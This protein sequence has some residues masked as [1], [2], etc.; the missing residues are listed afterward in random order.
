MAVRRFAA[1]AAPGVVALTLA[2]GG[3]S[4]AATRATPRIVAKPNNLMVDTKTTLT[5]SGFPARTRLSIVECSTTNWVVTAHPCVSGNKVSVMT[6]GRGRFT[7]SF[8][9]VLCRG[10]HGPEPTSQVCYVGNPHPYGIDTEHLDGAAKLTVT[11]P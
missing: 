1:L 11:Y 7:H 10:K 6:D 5:G 9:V 2:L 4:Y 8:E 3:S